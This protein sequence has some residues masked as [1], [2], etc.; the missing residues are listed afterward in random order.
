MVK[1][2]PPREARAARSGARIRET[3]VR[4]VSARGTRHLA[5]KE[6]LF[7]FTERAIGKRPGEIDPARFQGEPSVQPFSRIRGRGVSGVMNGRG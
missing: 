2:G 7:D 5:R 4:S 1:T 6:R 3:A